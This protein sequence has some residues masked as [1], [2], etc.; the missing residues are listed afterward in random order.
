[1]RDRMIFLVGARRS[2]TNWVQ[3][4]IGAHPEVALVPSETY[5]FSRGIKPLRERFHHGVLG[6]PGTA[7]VYMDPQEM[8][9]ALRNFCDG[10]F[11]PFLNAVPGATRLAERTPEHVTCLELIGEIYPD[12]WILNIV[13]DGRD[14]A[15]SLMKQ[16]WKNAPHTIEEAALEWRTSVEAA[17]TAS[18]GL[19]RFRTVRYEEM[20]VEPQAHVAELFGWFGLPAAPQ[21]VE[22]ALR[23]AKVAFNQDP[24]SGQVGAGKWREKISEADLN[25]LMKVAG[26]T[27]ERL[28][29]LA[30]ESA[31]M[32]PRAA[33]ARI[34]EPPLRR[35][36]GRLRGRGRAYRARSDVSQIT[37]I[38]RTL[39]RIAA[40]VVGRRANELNESLLGSVLVRVVAP[41]GD[42]KGRG[43]AAWDRL[44]EET[45]KD[46]ALDGRQ[47][48]GD[49]HP[50]VPTSTAL[51][52]FAAPDGSV[53]LRIL[54]VTLEDGQVARLTYYRF[55]VENDAGR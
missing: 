13:R 11:L 22:E 55:A 54:A 18:A 12:A 48:S 32:T 51:M 52:K 40:A 38:Q 42:W 50:G 20:L 24:T 16:P 3:R 44:A 34:P 1:M 2:G 23:E 41:G 37:D 46:P 36:R 4:I 10:V 5:L 45:R 7:F 53:H 25:A 47:V 26:E 30:P 43:G 17:E 39:D 27:L 14:V 8:T 9:R 6:S 28:G 15:R 19:E 29:Y 33:T 31:R 21:M 35:F 49:L